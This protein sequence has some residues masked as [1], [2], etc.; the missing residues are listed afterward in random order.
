VKH[1]KSDFDAILNVGEELCVF[2]DVETV[3][4]ATYVVG[5]AVLLHRPQEC[6]YASVG[7]V[8]DT[9][10]S[11][12]ARTFKRAPNL[13]QIKSQT[14]LSTSS[15][16]L[17]SIMNAVHET[18]GNTVPSPERRLYEHFFELFRILPSTVSKDSV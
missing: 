14:S 13:L 15:I 17:V 4:Q 18:F 11:A 6:V 7:T 5:T 1:W 8:R 10:L 3:L 16:L 2:L 12:D 9:M